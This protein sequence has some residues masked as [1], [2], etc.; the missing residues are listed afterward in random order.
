M[1]IKDKK[2]SY[3]KKTSTDCFENKGPP[4]VD[5]VYPTSLDGS[6]IK[7][8]KILLTKKSNNEKADKTKGKIGENWRFA[9]VRKKN[10][11][12]KVYGTMHIR[13]KD[14]NPNEWTEILPTK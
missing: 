3:D 6:N 7:E 14:S 9:V 4:E 2:K 11:D 12:G 1:K 5:H 8:N 13:K 10:K